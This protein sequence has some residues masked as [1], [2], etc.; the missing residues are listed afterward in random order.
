MKLIRLFS[1][2]ALAVAMVSC[3]TVKVVTDMDTTTDFSKY[4]TYSFLGWQDDSDRILTDMD[5]ETKE[6]KEL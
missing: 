5:G 4:S 3:S 2:I 6:P 1:L